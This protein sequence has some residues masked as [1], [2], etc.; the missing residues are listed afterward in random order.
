M[1]LTVRIPSYQAYLLLSSKRFC[2]RFL[3]NINLNKYN[4]MYSC[5]L[6]IEPGITPHCSTTLHTTSWACSMFVIA[7]F[8]SDL[9]FNYTY[10]NLYF[11]NPGGDVWTRW[12]TLRDTYVKKKRDIVSSKK[13]GSETKTKKN[14]KYMEILQ[15][16]DPYVQ[17]AR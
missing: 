15:F 7:A 3:R 12:R 16:L 13:S 11:S 10:F 6:E 5:L 14:W 8:Y 4:T 17:E 1:L 2:L 9:S